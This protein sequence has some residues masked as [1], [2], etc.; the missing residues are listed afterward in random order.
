LVLVDA[1]NEVFDGGG[2]RDGTEEFCVVVP[3]GLKV[4]EVKEPE[5]IGLAPKG[6]RLEAVGR[7]VE[8]DETIGVDGDDVVCMAGGGDIV[9][10]LT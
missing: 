8:L 2:S 10:V 1:E 7:K 4:D 9:G 3:V 6:F 5:E